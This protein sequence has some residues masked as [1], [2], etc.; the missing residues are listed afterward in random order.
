MRGNG[1]L[2][3]IAPEEVWAFQS[4]SEEADVA[5]D[6]LSEVLEAE[7][8][9]PTAVHL[10]NSSRSVAV[11]TVLRREI[12]WTSDVPG[13][14]RVVP[15]KPALVFR[16]Q[17]QYA[18]FI[19]LRLLEQGGWTGA[20]VKN[21]SGREFWTDISTPIVL[22]PAQAR[23]FEM[24]EQ[25]T[26]NRRGGCW[27]LVAWRNSEILFVES[28]QRSKDRISPAQ[29]IWFERALE[30]DVPLSSF[31]IAEYVIVPRPT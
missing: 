12:R 9:P 6:H 15:G 16:D 21:W 20:W 24:I 27:D 11:S 2:R 13:S 5:R 8:R 23:L 31:L 4:P 25:S 28:K 7:E 26:G 30:N 3:G 29:T 18:E 19:L 1:V 22:P 17:P 10:P 14:F